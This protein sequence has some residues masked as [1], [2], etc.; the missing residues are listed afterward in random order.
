[1]TVY[2][3]ALRVADKNKAAGRA[4]AL[5]HNGGRVANIDI[6]THT[7]RVQ[8]GSASHCQLYPARVS[9]SEAA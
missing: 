2:P 4:V 9:F 8:K 1:M 5:A 3:G 6:P 7:S